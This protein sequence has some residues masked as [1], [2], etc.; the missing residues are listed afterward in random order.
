[1]GQLGEQLR[2]DG[3]RPQHTD[4]AALHIRDEVIAGR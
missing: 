3:L 1:M 2:S 4:L